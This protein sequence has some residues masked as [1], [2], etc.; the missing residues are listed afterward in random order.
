M[1][2]YAVKAIIYIDA[3]D[4]ADAAKQ[5]AIID[6]GMSNRLL[7]IALQGEGARPLGHQVLPKPDKIP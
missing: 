6:R 3:K 7:K 5:A 2:K 4:D 1:A